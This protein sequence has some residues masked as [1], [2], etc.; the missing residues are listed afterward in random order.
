MENKK[1]IICGVFFLPFLISCI[2]EIK[3]KN[4]IIFKEKKL[5]F[6]HHTFS[7]NSKQENSYKKGDTIFFG[8]VIINDK[9]VENTKVID[10]TTFDAL[11]NYATERAKVKNEYYLRGEDYYFRDKKYIYIYQD[12]ILDSKTSPMFFIGGKVD[13]FAVLGGSYL[14]VGNKIYCKG[15]KLEDVDIS[16]FKTATLRLKN[17]EWYQ[18]IGFDKNAIYIEN[19]KEYTSNL[20]LYKNRIIGINLDSLQNFY[21]SQK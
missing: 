1:K 12:N 7:E 4:Y 18:T 17:S 21:S 10:P 16:T 6:K 19:R 15:I 3:N 13:D 5:Y 20:K 11:Y 2:Q 14:R 9:I 8:A